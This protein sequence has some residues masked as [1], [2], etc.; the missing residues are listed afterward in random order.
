MGTALAGDRLAATGGV[1][2]I[3][4]SAGG[5]LVP[6]ALIGGLGTA[7]QTGAAAF[8]T[9]V[10]PRDYSIEAC[11]LLVGIHD[12]LELSVAREHLGLGSTVPGAAI[13]QSIIGAKLRVLG[14]AIID[15]DSLLP[16]IAVGLQYKR[17]GSFDFVPRA[18]GARHADGTDVYVA[19]TKVWLAGPF[20]RSWLA[21]IT[22]RA[23]EANQLGLLGFGGD[24]GGYHVVPE[25]SLGVFLADALVLGGEY[26]HKANDLSAFRE[27]DFEDV[28]LAWWPAQWASLTVGYADL[29]SIAGKA[30]QQG[31]YVSLQL[32]W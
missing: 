12:R 2:Q 5:G 25:G 8:C 4:G 15:Q 18:L 9:N 14:D 17:N 19:A 28:F 27:D 3:E 10:A 21:D 24:L 7:E 22:L 32:G 1:T 26:R 30:G 20:G 16:Q 6:W 13:S 23:T 29:G 11:G 31:S